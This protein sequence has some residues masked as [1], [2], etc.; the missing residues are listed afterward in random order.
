MPDRATQKKH[1]DGAQPNRETSALQQPAFD[2]ASSSKAGDAAV[3]RMSSAAGPS[4]GNV[5]AGLGDPQKLAQ[6][7]LFSA[8]AAVTALEGEEIYHEG[9][10]RVRFDPGTRFSIRLDPGGLHLSANPGIEIDVP[11]PNLR[12]TS[13]SY[14]FQTAKFS[15]AGHASF[16]LFGAYAHVAME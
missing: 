9:H 3:R 16:D 5:G 15:A 6:E 14:D 7:A 10:V 1:D 2:T 4:L 13:V 11:G 8:D 12:L